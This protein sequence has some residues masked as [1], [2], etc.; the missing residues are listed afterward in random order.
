MSIFKDLRNECLIRDLQR[1]LNT[2]VLLFGYDGMVYFGNLQRVE[3]CRVAL[4]TA[5]IEAGSDVEILPPGGELVNVRFL[6]VDLWQI[7]AKASGVKANPL[8]P[9][10][11]AAVEKN[12]LETTDRQECR[13]LIR[14]LRR[15]IGDQVVI[16][17]LGGCVFEGVLGDVDDEL[18]FMSVEE[19]LV[20]ANASVIS[21][22]EVSTAVISLAAITSVSTV[23][24]C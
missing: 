15:M 1:E 13:E 2:D 21:S 22:S 3:D 23:I 20:P 6:H 4:L 9:E 8:V 10:P 18:A 24:C 14:T 19:I 12:R 5:A 11:I 16:T 17:T 7:I